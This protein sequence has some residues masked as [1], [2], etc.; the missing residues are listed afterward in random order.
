LGPA[1]V[2]LYKCIDQCVVYLKTRVYSPREQK[3][4]LEIGSDDGIKLWIN[5]KLVHAKNAMRPLQ[6]GEDTAEAVLKE[7]GRVPRL[8]ETP[9][10]FFP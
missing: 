9:H 4:R 1:D 8:A 7:G 6:P 10:S 5:G 3:V 2:H